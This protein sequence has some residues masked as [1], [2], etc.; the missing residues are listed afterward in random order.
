MHRPCKTVDDHYCCIITAAVFNAESVEFNRCR[1]KKN[2]TRESFL[3]GV[4][5]KIIIRDSMRELIALNIYV[6]FLVTNFQNC[7][8]RSL[9]F[10]D[11]EI[12][13]IVLTTSTII[14]L[15]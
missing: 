8:F 3:K 15:L 2:I 6:I 5:K 7:I 4:P 14:L 12:L 13:Q 11:D 1:A 10:F 9:L